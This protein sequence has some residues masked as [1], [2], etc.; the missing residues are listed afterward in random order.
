MNQHTPIPSINRTKT[1][2]SKETKV[3]KHLVSNQNQRR[4]QD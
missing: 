1:F 3:R 4:N 2:I